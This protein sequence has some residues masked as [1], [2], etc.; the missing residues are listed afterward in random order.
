MQASYR[1]QKLPI[2]S[3]LLQTSGPGPSHTAEVVLYS[4]VSSCLS[5][6]LTLVPTGKM[7]NHLV[8]DMKVSLKKNSQERQDVLVLHPALLLCLSLPGRRL[9][10]WEVMFAARL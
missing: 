1:T 8:F 10:N 6:G 5:R 3:H 4:Q 7:P 2:P 9:G